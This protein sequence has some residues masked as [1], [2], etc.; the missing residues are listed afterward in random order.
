MVRTGEDLQLIRILVCAAILATSASPA[1]AATFVVTTT[2][3]DGTGSLRAAIAAAEASAGTDAIRIEATGRIAL[4]SPLQSLDGPL[5][6]AG[7]GADRLELAR[8]APEPFRILSVAAGADVTVEGLAVGGGLVTDWTAAHGGGIRNAGRLELRGVAVAG[9]EVA[10]PG[11]LAAGGGIYNAGS[12]ALKRSVV[13]GNVVRAPGGQASG[14]G[15]HNVGTVVVE[16]STVRGNWVAGA[17]AAGAA[18]VIASGD[19]TV[20]RSTIVDN[21]GDGGEL[22]AIRNGSGSL[23]IENSTLAG[24]DGGVGVQ[25]PGTTTIASSTIASGRGS[26]LVG[27]ASDVDAF[28]RIR[29]TILAGAP[30]C[31][32]RAQTVVTSDGHNLADDDSCEFLTAPGDRRGAD[33]ALGPLRDNG[34]GTETMALGPG[35]A[36][37]DGGDAGGLTIDQRGLPR[38]AGGGADVGAFEVQPRPPGGGG[39][40]GGA[41]HEVAPTG[42]PTD[43]RSHHG[44]ARGPSARP[45]NAFR[46]GIP[47]RRAR[48]RLV[49]PVHVSGPGKLVLAGRRI[50]RVARTAPASRTVLLPVMP[51]NRFRSRKVR[52]AVTYTPA[53]GLPRVRSASVRMGRAAKRPA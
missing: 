53:G 6:I 34:G 49:L 7:P 9:N 43:G 29:S 33:P 10:A 14:G 18:I 4:R 23:T 26:N 52:V 50:R 51:R 47:R 2:D 35:S 32:I 13:S 36:A 20:R 5:A 44:L 40:G 37:I 30:N 19:A 24:N 3:D 42:Q 8:A 16:E 31:A 39:P 41:P 25:H 17:F 48:G 38:A 46:L 27:F 21:R 45:S 28:I 11:V 12:L 15:I 1:R 22:T